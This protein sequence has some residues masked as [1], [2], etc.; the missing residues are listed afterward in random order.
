MLIFL[1]WQV[2][3]YTPFCT[4]PITCLCRS[5]LVWDSGG[6]LEN[7]PA[8]ALR[9]SQSAS[10]APLRQREGKP[11]YPCIVTCVY[12][13]KAIHNRHRLCFYEKQDALV[14]LPDHWTWWVPPSCQAVDHLVSEHTGTQLPGQTCGN[15]YCYYRQMNRTFLLFS[16]SCCLNG[17]CECSSNSE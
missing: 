7:L 14:F 3:D 4:D 8:T 1:Q 10:S 13:L 6:G 17:C 5:S 2:T 9:Y 11:P 15:I 16:V 12:L